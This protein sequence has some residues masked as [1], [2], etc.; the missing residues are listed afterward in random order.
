MSSNSA[1]LAPCGGC[2]DLV[3]PIHVCPIGSVHM[4]PF[5]GKPVGLEG[6]GQHVVYPDC[7]SGKP[8]AISAPPIL[9][10]FALQGNKDAISSKDAANDVG[11]DESSEDDIISNSNV[12]NVTELPMSTS[13][14]ASQQVTTIQNR[15]RV[16]SWMEEYEKASGAKNMFARAVDQFPDNF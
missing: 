16:I 1:Q 12:A 2:G 8:Q 4:H 6:F 7:D 13:S 5:C 15:R 14:R 11:S 9:K 10:A 3:G